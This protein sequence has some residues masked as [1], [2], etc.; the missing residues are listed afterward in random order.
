M[1]HLEALRP[2][3]DLAITGTQAAAFEI[4]RVFLK[5]EDLLF[6][7]RYSRC[8]PSKAA[9]RLPTSFK[10]QH[11]FRHFASRFRDTARRTR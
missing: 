2:Q 1:P 4:K 7:C 3:L 6:T 10:F 9:A 5:A 11:Y 8:L